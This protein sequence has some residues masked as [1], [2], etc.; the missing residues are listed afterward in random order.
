MYLVLS[1]F[2]AAGAVL[3]AAPAMSAAARMW[4]NRL[5][6]S[7]LATVGQE[8]PEVFVFVD[9]NRYAW[10][11]V[12]LVLTAC[13]VVGV[14]TRSGLASSVA[15][16]LALFIPAMVMRWLRRRRRR[17]LLRQLPGCLD[18]IAVSLRSGLALLPAIQHLARNQPPPIGQ[19]LALV[20]RRHRLGSSI[21]VALEDLHRRMGGFEAALFVTAVGVARQLGGNLSEILA[22]LSQTLRERQAIEAKITALTAQ[23]RLQARIVAL[24][25]LALLLVLNRM[26]PRAMQLMYTTP[27]G[28]AALLVLAVLEVSGMLLLRRLVRIEV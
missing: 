3:L 19:E 18:L 22:R 8:L 14:L 16:A 4:A 20:I 28:W 17:A 15:G 13:I 6:G 1:A 5:H 9:P 7:R 24:L 27:Q 10:M 23:G 21:D 26:E 2:A 25:P 12:G 11:L